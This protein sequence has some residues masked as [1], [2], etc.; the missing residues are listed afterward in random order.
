MLWLSLPFAVL[1]PKF[2]GVAFGFVGN[3]TASNASLIM[4]WS[5]GWSRPKK[6]VCGWR[7]KATSSYTV[8]LRL[9]SCLSGLH[10]WCANVPFPNT[11]AKACPVIANLLPVKVAKRTGCGA[12]STFR[13][14]LLQV[15]WS[16]LPDRVR[17]KVFV[18]FLFSFVGTI[19]YAQVCGGDDSLLFHQLKYW[20]LR[21]FT[22]T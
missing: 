6:P 19:T 16:V 14:R 5:L 4:R 8:S 17:K 3:A 12:K 7:P 18:H 13:P 10:R 9:V 11:A 1:R 20:I 22:M 15:D 21:W 2:G